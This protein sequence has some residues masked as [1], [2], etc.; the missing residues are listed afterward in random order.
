LSLSANSVAQVSRNFNKKKKPLYELG[1]G[2]ITLNIPNYPGAGS[3]TPRYIPVPLVI[4]RGDLFRQDEDGSRLRLIN[5]DVFELGM[6]GGFNFQIDSDEN[7]SRKGMPD[8]DTLFGI[9]PGI[10]VRLLKG[11][12]LNKLTLGLGLRINLAFGND[13]F[14][15]KEQGWI[16]E[17][18][19]RYWR[20]FSKD[21]AFSLFSGLSMSY[22]D[23]KYNQ[24][25]YQVNDRYKT[26]SRDSYDA[27]EGVV[28]IAG[29]IGGGYDFSDKGSV[30]LGLFQSNLTT[31][32][33]KSSPLVE[34][35]V[36]TGIVAGFTWLFF[37]SKDLVE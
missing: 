32:A 36:N 37:Q 31:A 18:N 16:I 24:F 23:K 26:S 34:E 35:Q 3:N 9:G 8:T 13:F 29:S 6:S 10:I 11:D 1:A 21:S 27:K 30:F 2:L 4:Y 5:S 15:V 17:P 14:F 19:I 22:G 25:F 20:K 28:D 12:P 7:K 33:N